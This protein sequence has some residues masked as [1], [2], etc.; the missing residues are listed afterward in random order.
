MITVA[1]AARELGM[2]KDGVYYR[3]R[4]GKL[5]ASVVDG[6]LMVFSSDLE[7][8]MDRGPKPNGVSEAIGM[9]GM[10]DRL[11]IINI[12]AS[13]MTGGEWDLVKKLSKGA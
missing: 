1:E 11:R 12:V 9:L 7:E 5:K 6:K 3:I 2:T 13:R 4:R 8:R 10:N